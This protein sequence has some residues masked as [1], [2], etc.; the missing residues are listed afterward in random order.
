MVLT[1]GK[2]FSSDILTDDHKKIISRPDNG[3]S[4]KYKTK[5]YNSFYFRQCISHWE[6]FLLNVL[7]MIKQ[8]LTRKH[9]E[10]QVD[11]VSPRKYSTRAKHSLLDWSSEFYSAT[12]VISWLWFL[13]F[14]KL[15]FYFHSSASPP[16]EDFGNPLS[17]PERKTSGRTK[18]QSEIGKEIL[19]YCIYERR[20][21]WR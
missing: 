10:Y 3:M 16:E 7:Y 6:G 14:L 12:I 13:Q 11:S 1:D 20:L 4:S 8:I 15:I 21:H 18:K 9:V 17:P 19:F 5:Q 2:Q